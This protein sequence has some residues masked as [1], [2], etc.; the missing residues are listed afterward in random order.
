M[1]DLEEALAQLVEQAPAPPEVAT[2][3]RRARQGRARRYGTAI[4]AALVVVIGVAGAIALRPTHHRKVILERPPTESV[5][6]TLLD[7]SQLEIRGPKSLGLTKLVP[8]FNSQLD[9]PNVPNVV[10]VGH[11]FTV[12]RSAPDELLGAELSRYPTGDG[13]ELVVYASGYGVFGVVRYPAWALVAPWNHDPTDWST[14]ASALHARPTA[15]GFL[16]FTPLEPGWKLGAP[17]SPDVQLGGRAEFAFFGPRTYPS[18]CPTAAETQPRTPQGWPVSRV[19]GTWW[20][21]P[22]QHVRIRVGDPALVDDAIRGLRVEYTEADRAVDNVTKN[23][24]TLDGKSFE[25]T[26]PTTVLDRFFAQSTLVVDGLTTTWPLVISVDRSESIATRERRETNAT[27]DGNQLV[28]VRGVDG[29]QWLEGKYG[30]WYLTIMA[31]DVS[32]ED[33]PHRVVVRGP[34]DRRRISR[35][36]SARPDASHEGP[37]SRHLAQR[38]RHLLLGGPRPRGRGRRNARDRRPHPRPP[39]RLTRRVQR[40][41]ATLMN[42]KCR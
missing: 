13:H 29:E 19:N 40:F 34:R 28:G 30:D 17:D 18:G 22:D 5:R 36:R 35:A 3:T 37:P 1:I 33:R 20:C 16:V 6:M 31:T 12:Q 7:G 38:R 14:F 41:P 15:D 10:P 8:A 11:S 21:D 26:G 32:G 39:H 25:I 23:V 27:A 24:T 4:A 42:E 9:M 2:V